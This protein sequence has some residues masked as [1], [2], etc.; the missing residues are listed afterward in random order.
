MH[1]LLSEK[2]TIPHRMNNSYRMP[3]DNIIVY[4]AQN[5]EYYGTNVYMNENSTGSTRYL[6]FMIWKWKE[7]Q[8][9]RSNIHINVLMS[10][11]CQARIRKSF[12]FRSKIIR[13]FNTT[14][15]TESIVIEAY[16]SNWR[17]FV[18]GFVCVCACIGAKCLLAVRKQYF[19]FRLFISFCD[20]QA[21]KYD[22]R[23]LIICRINISIRC[24]K[25][26]E[27]KSIWLCVNQRPSR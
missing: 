17:R 16:D 14:L 7:K 21:N 13:I 19:F 6:A 24:S 20:N 26:K 18:F 10:S 5:R 25:I 9:K 15:E 11:R 4:I 12:S 27:M 22:S 3:Y 2:L 23:I 1:V 8:K